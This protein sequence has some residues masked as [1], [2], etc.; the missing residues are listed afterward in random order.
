MRTIKKNSKTNQQIK[1]FL[2]SL[3]NVLK[4]NYALT[5]VFASPVARIN[6]ISI[7][8]CSLLRRTVILYG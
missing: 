6:L 7:S 4:R 1:S 5:I 3:G 2:R 8:L